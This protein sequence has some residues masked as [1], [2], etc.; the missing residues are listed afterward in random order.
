MRTKKRYRKKEPPKSW[1]NWF[2]FSRANENEPFQKHIPGCHS[3]EN[4]EK[5]IDEFIYRGSEREY[6]VRYIN[7][8]GEE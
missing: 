1:A 8:N 4:A 3:R 6:E 5:R 2:I 7:P